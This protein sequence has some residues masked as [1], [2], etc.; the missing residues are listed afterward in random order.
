MFASKTDKTQVSEWASEPNSY[1]IAVLDK[2]RGKCQFRWETVEKMPVLA[3]Y[4]GNEIYSFY[5]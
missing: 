3:I 1:L 4:Y 5:R 2:H